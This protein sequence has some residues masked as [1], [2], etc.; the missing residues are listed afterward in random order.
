MTT[1]KKALCNLLC[2]IL[3]GKKALKIHDFYFSR[4]LMKCSHAI[5]RHQGGVPPGH[6]ENLP[7][8]RDP[9][10]G[11]VGPNPLPHQLMAYAKLLT[12]SKYVLI[13]TIGVDFRAHK[14]FQ[15]QVCFHN[16]GFSC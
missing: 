11:G 3:D 6:F 10:L 7:L 16:F 9:G 12:D 8:P 5:L 15:I 14:S 13:F 4:P 1:A 2:S